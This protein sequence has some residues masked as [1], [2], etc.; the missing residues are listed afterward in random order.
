MSRDGVRPELFHAAQAFLVDYLGYKGAEQLIITGDT[1]G[2]ADVIS[3]L[4]SAAVA[5][6]GRPLV[7]LLMRGPR[8]SAS[9]EYG[10]R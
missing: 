6:G 9:S 1:A 2:D 10:V 5:A 8:R 7:M 4:S 3:A